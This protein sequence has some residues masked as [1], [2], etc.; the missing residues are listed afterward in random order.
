MKKMRVRRKARRRTDCAACGKRLRSQRKYCC[1]VCAFR[2]MFK[3]RVQVKCATCSAV[4]LVRK[5][6]KGPYCSRECYW[7][8]KLI[9]RVTRPCPRCGR[10]MRLKPSSRRVHCSRECQK[11]MNPIVR[12]KCVA[13][14]RQYKC[15]E[16]D[17][18]RHCSHGCS[19]QWKIVKRISR[20]C[21][22]CGKRM[23]VRV[24]QPKKIFCS[25]N[26]ARNAGK[27]SRKGL[28]KVV[29]AECGK[30]FSV[31]TRVWY[32]RT[33]RLFY[34]SQICY[35]KFCRARKGP[36]PNGKEQ[37]LLRLLQPLGFR[38]T[39][40]GQFMV[41]RKCPDFVHV[42]LP[43]IVELFGEQYHR[44]GSEK[45]RVAFFRTHGYKCLVFWCRTLTRRPLYIV[46]KVRNALHEF[47]RSN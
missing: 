3:P 18:K 2:G 12:R 14:G 29:C 8:A 9:K 10:L 1:R 46:D 37:D 7:Q 26:C 33:S 20:P 25:L 35:L 36:R 43:F 15:R 34:C 13:C 19:Y 47:P 24:D 11:L 41:E 27:G 23:R 17:P 16:R 21:K 39:G 45:A 6:Q 32:E 4:F 28:V 40:A 31:L 42:K 5:S 44:P 38:Y 22:C 30:Q